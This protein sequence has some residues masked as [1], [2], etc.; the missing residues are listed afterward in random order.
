VHD[1]VVVLLENRPNIHLTTLSNITGIS[2][3]FR[4]A[5]CILWSSIFSAPVLSHGFETVKIFM[6]ICFLFSSFIHIFVYFGE[7]D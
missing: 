6:F 7:A 4:P 2:Q 5:V 1:A 3:L